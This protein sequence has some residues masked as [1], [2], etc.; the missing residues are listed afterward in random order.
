LGRRL[1]L[2]VWDREVLARETG[3]PMVSDVDLAAVEPAGVEALRRVMAEV[4]RRGDALVVGRGG[5][6]L[7]R[8]CPS[9]LRVKL[10]T[11][12]GERVRRVMEYRWIDDAAAQAAIAESDARRKAFYQQHFGVNWDSPLEFDLVVNTAAL[13]PRTADLIVQAARL[14]WYGG[15]GA[16]ATRSPVSPSSGG[17]AP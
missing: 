4:G 12:A 14:K 15:V 7:L 6:E 10:I 9:A 8:D 16:K 17:T 1:H 13:G 5:S 2:K 11:P 3:L